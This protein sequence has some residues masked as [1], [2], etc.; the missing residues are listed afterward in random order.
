MKLFYMSLRHTRVSE[1]VQKTAYIALCLQSSAKTYPILHISH[2]WKNKHVPFKWRTVLE[3]CIKPVNAKQLLAQRLTT[4][5]LSLCRP[6]GGAVSGQQPGEVGTDPVLQNRWRGGRGHLCQRGESTNWIPEI[7]K[8]QRLHFRRVT[9]W[10]L[11]RFPQENFSSFFLPLTLS[12][13]IT[14]KRGL[15]LFDL[16]PSCFALRNGSKTCKIYTFTPLCELDIKLFENEKKEYSQAKK[17]EATSQFSFTSFFLFLV[18]PTPFTL[19]SKGNHYH[20]WRE[21]NGKMW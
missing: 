21:C 13:E 1:F 10:V 7:I 16:L 8:L 2:A 12:P 3:F 17:A 11:L 19:Q 4:W 9:L 5:V 6:G 14:L 18:R 20:G 15:H